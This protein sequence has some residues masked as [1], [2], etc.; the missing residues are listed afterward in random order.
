LHAYVSLTN[1]I[2]KRKAK[3]IGLSTF[4][5]ELRFFLKKLLQ[6]IIYVK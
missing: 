5:I 2:S 4:D 3:E 1:I 6:K